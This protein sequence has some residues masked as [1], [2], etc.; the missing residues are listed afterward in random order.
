MALG[1]GAPMAWKNK[2]KADDY[3][4]AMYTFEKRS[5]PYPALQVFDAP[6]GELP[7]TRRIRSNTP[8][9]AL[10]T[11][12]DP[13]FVEAA[14]AMALRVWK[15]GGKDDK[16]RIDYAFQ[17]CTGRNPDKKEFATISSLLDDS[18]NLFENQTTRAIEV[19]SHD[20]KNPTP[21]VN[22]HKVAAWT[23][24]SRVLLNMDATITKE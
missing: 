23:M 1:Y 24:V 21:D 11:L 14:Q 16:S 8:L 6:T 17:L 18:E 2:N 7:C 20:P 5:V 12:N 15:D 19:A 3:R 13:V 10:D 22:L 4:R 9:Q